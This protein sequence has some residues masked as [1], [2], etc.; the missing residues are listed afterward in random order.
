[1]RHLSACETMGGA[2][3]ICTDKTGTLT[4]NRMTVVEGWMA[5]SCVAGPPSEALAE[6]S[7]SPEVRACDVLRLSRGL[8]SLLHLPMMPEAAP[9]VEPR[10]FLQPLRVAGC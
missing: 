7:S 5:G 1:M 6:G 3:C 4:Q 10:H 2:T 8:R 9:V